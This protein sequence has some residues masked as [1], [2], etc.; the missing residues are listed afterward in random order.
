[1]VSLLG[2]VVV[3]AAPVLLATSTAGADPI[4]S[5][6]SQIASVEAQIAASAGRIHQLTSAFDQANLTAT[7]GAQ[8]LSADQ[9]TL[10]AA[11]A[12]LAGTEQALRQDALRSYTGG[13][14]GPVADTPSVALDPGVSSAYIN[15]AVGDLSDSVDQFHLQQQQLE[16]DVAEVTA[17][18]RINQQALTA[19]ANARA[20]ALAEAGAAQTKLAALQ[21]RL[22]SLEAAQ[23]AAAAAA[24][25]AAPPR[26][27]GGPVGNGLVAVVTAIVQAPAPAP[28]VA[29]PAAPAA[30]A[31]APA[32]AAPVQAPAA[33]AAPA[34]TPPSGG[35]WLQLRECESGD[36]YQENT[37]NGFFGAYQF[38]PST[39]SGL[40]FPGRPDLEPPAMQDQAAV[41]LQASSGWGAW[42]ACSAALGLH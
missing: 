35:V 21:S 13:S 6:Q 28:A 26:S 31:P 19:A 37:G 30:P 20:A 40:G 41:K 17:Q 2:A 8:Q 34:A 11:R 15:V 1:M 9:A 38:S 16:A 4:G 39:W 3:F 5:T 29:A 12:R 7:T 24:R 32:V 42:P 14:V 23:A 36:N 33:P 18:Q 10:A 25:A 22:G 27:Q